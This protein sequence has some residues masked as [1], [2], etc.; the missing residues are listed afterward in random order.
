MWVMQ[1]KLTS[2][3]RHFTHWIIS[4]VSQFHLDTLHVLSCICSRENTHDRDLLPVLTV[5]LINHVPLTA[6]FNSAPHFHKGMEAVPT[7]QGWVVITLIN[8][9]RMHTAWQA[10]ALLFA[11]ADT[12]EF[13]SHVALMS[14]SVLIPAPIRLQNGHCPWVILCKF[15]Q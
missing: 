3:C 8:I 12:N 2:S 5:A 1:F 9:F 15:Q 7:S 14:K 13:T 10:G 6:V 4:L 11:M